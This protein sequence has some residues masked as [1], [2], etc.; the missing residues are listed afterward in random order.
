M[1]PR[2]AL[3]PASLVVVTLLGTTAFALA[4][5][6]AD[7]SVSAAQVAATTV[8]RTA[9]ERVL[10]WA[11][12]PSRVIATLPE[13]VSLDAL[14]RDA[15]WIEVRLPEKFGGPGGQTGYVFEGHIAVESGPPLSTLPMRPTAALAPD[16]RA[17]AQPARPRTPAFGVRGY[18]EAAY[19]WFAAKESFDAIFETSS[20]AFYGGGGQVHFGPIY[21]DVGISRF[22]KT[23]ERVFV[24]ED[25]IF[26]LGIP[27]RVT[28][29]PLVV[30]AGYRFPVRDRMVPYVG[31]GIGSLQFEE[32]SDEADPDENVSE[33]FTSYHVAGGVEYAAS[34]WLFVGGEV[35]YAWVPD[36]LGAPG[37][38]AEFDE[39][40]LGGVSVAVKVMIGR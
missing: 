20:G 24:F 5:T 1:S 19:Q 29:T 11:R 38:S 26:R 39:S 33:R 40:D 2:F 27:D 7:P 9:R 36:A 28:I 22:E 35:R 23:G 32:T 14:S 16:A 21:V 13:G 8:V 12:N 31:G 25:E 18:G 10:V 15:Q 17:A 37:V 4:Q 3:L 6:P 34:R 30:M